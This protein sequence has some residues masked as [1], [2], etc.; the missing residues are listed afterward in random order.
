MGGGGNWAGGTLLILLGVA[1]IARTI[2][3]TLIPT[4]RRSL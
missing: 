1:I 4:V 3:G 2:H